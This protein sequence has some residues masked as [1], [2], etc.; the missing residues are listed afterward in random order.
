MRKRL[1]LGIGAVVAAVLT[2]GSIYAA[3]D[4]STLRPMSTYRGLFQHMLLAV[5]HLWSTA[6][7][8]APLTHFDA[9]AMFYARA[10]HLLCPL[11]GFGVFWLISRHRIG[12]SIWKPLAI[13]VAFT[14]PLYA[15]LYSPLKLLGLH[16]EWAGSGRVIVVF[17][18]MV[19]SVG[20]V[21]IPKWRLASLLRSSRGAEMRPDCS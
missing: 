1:S 15:L 17:L 9:F 4:L 10:V 20:A 21:H 13:A 11:I 18:L 16:V 2:H 19:W 6:H 3:I 5:E 7:G 8:W 14:T 12:W